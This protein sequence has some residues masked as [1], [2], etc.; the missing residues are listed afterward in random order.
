[1]N[2]EPRAGTGRD[3]LAN[4]LFRAAERAAAT[5]GVRLGHGADGDIR[6]FAQTA[7]DRLLADGGGRVSLTDRAASDATAAFTRL[8]EE[9]VLASSQ[10]PN[11]RER[12]PGIIGEET[13]AR[14]LARLCPL[15]PIC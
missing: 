1:M 9:M 4:A 5:H 10:I 14:A 8:V 7:A 2:V 6:R 15:Y 12:H 3:D 11:Y 13:L